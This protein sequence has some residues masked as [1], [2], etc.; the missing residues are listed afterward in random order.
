MVGMNM[1]GVDITGACRSKGVY[2]R[3]LPFDEVLIIHIQIGTLRHKTV[4]AQTV[5]ILAYPA[6]AARTRGKSNAK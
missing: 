1:P 2:N 6:G 5:N 4:F 3:R